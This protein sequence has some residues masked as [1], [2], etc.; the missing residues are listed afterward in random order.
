M[1]DGPSAAA[2]AALEASDPAAAA[3]ARMVNGLW[4]LV[5]AAGLLATAVASRRARRWRFLRGWARALVADYGCPLAFVAWTAISFAVRG[6]PGAPRRVAT[7]NT[8]EM[9]PTW[10]V[11]GRMGEVPPV[12]VGAALVPALV[13]AVLFFFDHNVGA[14]PSPP[15]APSRACRRR[16]RAAAC[17]APHTPRRGARALALRQVSSQ[18]AQQPEFNLKRPAAYHWDMAL[19]GALVRRHSRVLARARCRRHYAGQQPHAQPRSHPAHPS[20]RADAAV[21]PAGPAAHQRRAAA[22]A[23]AHARARA[24]QGRASQAQRRRRGAGARA[25][26]RSRRR[27]GRGGRRSCGGGG[28]RGRR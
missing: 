23:D 27:A 1:N 14:P 26:Q 18:M 20:P 10:G 6:V 13:I 11:A 19:L 21:G 5:L 28:S 9:P 12:F 2:A 8:W 22:G 24:A 15:P 17:R 16:A 7:P 25:A 3:L 4:A